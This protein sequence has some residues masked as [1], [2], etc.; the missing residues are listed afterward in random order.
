M[1]S[2]SGLGRRRFYI[3]ARQREKW[4]KEKKRIMARGRSRMPLTN[5]AILP[6]LGEENIGRGR[7]STKNSSRKD[8]YRLGLKR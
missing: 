8:N 2:H 3:G 6:N 7:R 4:K 5:D 1:P